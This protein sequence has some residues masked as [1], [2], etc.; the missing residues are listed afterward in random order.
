VPKQVNI[1]VIM[2]IDFLRTFSH[3]ESDNMMIIIII[4]YNLMT[5]DIETGTKYSRS[6][7]LVLFTVLKKI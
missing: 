6:S 3:T 4:I 2:L 7:G 5:S 1:Y